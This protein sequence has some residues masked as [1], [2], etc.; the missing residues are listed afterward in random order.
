MRTK[1]KLNL[2]V[3][4]VQKFRRISVENGEESVGGREKAAS[5]CKC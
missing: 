3:Y 2:G 1:S 4:S 5:K